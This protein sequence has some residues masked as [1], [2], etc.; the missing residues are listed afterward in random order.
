[1][2]IKG[3]VEGNEYSYNFVNDI[4]DNKFQNHLQNEV[5][6]LS[7]KNYIILIYP[8]PEVGFNV[9]ERTRQMYYEIY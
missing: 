6:K 8:I 1:M 3:G 2:T 7:N 5:K 4:K 9:P